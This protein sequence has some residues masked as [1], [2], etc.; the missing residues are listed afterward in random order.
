MIQTG[1]ESRV[2]IQQIIS[3]Q[4]PNFILDESPNTSEFLK[5]YYVSQEYQGGPVDIAENLDQYLKLDNL[6]PEVV[7][8]SVN[9]STGI[10]TD[11]S[12]GI[13]TVTSTKGFPQKYGLLK[14]DDEII[15]YT[16]ITTNTFTGCIRGFS[17]ITNYHSDLNQEELVFSKSPVEEHKENSSV[18]NLSSL[19]LK[20]FYK[21][22][23]S[24]FTPGLEEYDFVNDLNVGNF[25]RE[26]RS[27]YQAKGTDE[28]F[29][30]LFNVLYGVTPRVVNLENFLIKP[31]SSEFIRREV[32]VVEKISG[33]PGKLVGQTIVKSTDGSTNASVSEVEPFT[34]DNKQYHKISLFVGYEDSSAVVG[35]FTITPNT[36]CLENVSIG[37]S[38]ISVDSTIGFPQQG[39][40]VSGINTTITYTSKSI[41]QF[42]GCLGI[43]S[44]ILSSA[45]IRTDEIYFGYENGD[46]D[47]KVEL[48]LCGV[49]SKFVQI[50]DNLN[51]DE[52]EIISVKHI[53]S[54]IENPT[55]NKTYKEI[56][57]NSWIYNTSSRYQIS[58]I[59]NFTLK[60]P[61]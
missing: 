27:F 56:F 60:S 57:A 15:T 9:L 13:I 46:P 43:T 29:R 47:K 40:I 37:A 17:G 48:R 16:G 25:I 41:N 54:K 31:S 14:I 51:L 3:S 26:A 20:E 53:G 38:I 36:K 42:F 59:S 45:N 39:T 22:I 23:K 12:V 18:Q 34:R 24:T 2:K 10:G 61:Y 49:L 5:Q 52:G 44:S 6:T 33:D 35:N 50:S 30:I 4:L 1:V 8:D 19:F 11:V 7:V 21:K 32:I 55:Y 58:D 28:S